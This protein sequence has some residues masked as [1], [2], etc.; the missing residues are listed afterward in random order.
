[1]FRCTG[2]TAQAIRRPLALP[3]LPSALWAQ[4]GVVRKQSQGG[5]VNVDVVRL[6]RWRLQADLPNPRPH[7]M[8]NC[9]EAFLRFSPA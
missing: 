7:R 2:R 4:S 1:M 8:E 9:A 3:E 5:Q 6:G